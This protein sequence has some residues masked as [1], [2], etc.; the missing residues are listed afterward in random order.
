MKHSYPEDKWVLVPEAIGTRNGTKRDNYST[1]EQEL[2]AGMLLLSS[3]LNP[4]YWGATLWLG[5]VTK[6]RSALC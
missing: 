4:D 5:Y 6:N 3:L 1:Y 2:F